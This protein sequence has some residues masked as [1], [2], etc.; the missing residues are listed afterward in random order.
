MNLCI[1][2]KDIKYHNLIKVDAV[3]RRKSYDIMQLQ[4]YLSDISEKLRGGRPR[5]VGQTRKFGILENSE[6]IVLFLPNVL[7]I[8]Q[9]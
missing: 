9:N 5:G 8:H 7:N 2:H 6:L 4:Q 3:N 1:P